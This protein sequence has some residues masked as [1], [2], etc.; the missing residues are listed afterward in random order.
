MTPPTWILATRNAHK[1]EEL[2]ALLGS[3][4]CLQSLDGLDLPAELPETGRTLE[5]NSAQKA[6]FVWEH[7]QIPCLADD[8][9]L[10]V[11]ALGGAPGVDSAHYSG[12]RDDAGNLARVLHELQT[13]PDRTARFRCVLS[14]YDG[15]VVHS[16]EG[17]CPGHMAE[18]PAGDHGFGYDPAFVPEGYT[19]TFGQ[20]PAEVKNALSHRARAAQQLVAWLEGGSTMA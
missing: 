1:V 3:R 6:R 19:Q 16:F 15:H 10:E 2:Q 14:L 17:S 13:R 7:T 11:A 5:E 18:A 4:V 12:R 9:G 8:S 20:L